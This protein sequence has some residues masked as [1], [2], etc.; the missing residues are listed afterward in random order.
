MGLSQRF[1]ANE[2]IETTLI[3]PYPVSQ[4][5]STLVRGVPRPGPDTAIAAMQK[6][7]TN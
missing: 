6:N 4:M 3:I 7:N 1:A 2:P 5:D